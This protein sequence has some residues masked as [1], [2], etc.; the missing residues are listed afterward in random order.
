M[1]KQQR[2]QTIYLKRVDYTSKGVPIELKAG[3]T[4]S[5]QIKFVKTMDK[6]I[7]E[8]RKPHRIRLI[9][10]QSVQE[11]I[12]EHKKISWHCSVCRK[13]LSSKRS[14]TEHMNIHKGTRP[15]ACENCDYAAASQMTLHRHKL[16]NHTPRSEWGYKCPYCSESY[17]EPASYQQHVQANHVGRSATYGCPS[18]ACN[19]I[20]K[21]QRHFREHLI[22]HNYN[23]SIGGGEN[24]GSLSNDGLIRFLVNDEFGAGYQPKKSEKKAV[25]RGRNVAVAITRPPFVVHPISVRLK[26]PEDNRIAQLSIASANVPK[27]ETPSERLFLQKNLNGASVFRRICVQPTVREPV[28]DSDDEGPPVLEQQQKEVFASD[29]DWIEAEVEVSTNSAPFPNGLIDDDLD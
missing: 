12:T 25:I 3:H 23:E 29:N 20:S 15:F 22:K 18:A 19:F 27:G 9:K 16:R 5:D 10:A 11:P 6:V 21:S 4:S 17:M 28:T 26:T 8:P 13:E 14:Y 24:L 2:V 7:K 1:I